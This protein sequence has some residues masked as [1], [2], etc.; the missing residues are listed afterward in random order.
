MRAVQIRTRERLSDCP[1][2]PDRD[3]NEQA[4]RHVG[5]SDGRDLNEL[6]VRGDAVRITGHEHRCRMAAIRVEYLA[7]LHELENEVKAARR[8]SVD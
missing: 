4:V 1:T 6:L 5:K 2:A 7:H 3:E 8:G